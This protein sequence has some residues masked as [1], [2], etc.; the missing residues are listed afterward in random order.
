MCSNL[1]PLTKH[2]VNNIK[3]AKGVTIRAQNNLIITIK[4]ANG[5]TQTIVKKGDPWTANFAKLILNILLGGHHGGT[6]QAWTYT[7]GSTGTMIDTDAIG[8]NPTFAIAIGN[9]T[10]PFSVDDY[11]LSNQITLN[12]VPSDYIAFSDN[13]TCYNINA[14]SSFTVS[15]AVNITEVGLLIKVDSDISGSGTT[16][17]YILLSRDLLDTPVHLEANDTI[18]VQYVIYFSYGSPPLTKQFYALMLNY[19]FG[20][21]AYGKAISFK[22]TDGT[23]ASGSDFSIDYYNPDNVLYL[24]NV[25]ENLYAWLGNGSNIWGYDNYTLSNKIA[26]STS[27][28]PF[29]LT[30]NSTH[31]KFTVTITYSFSTSNT[32][33]EVGFVIQSIDIDTGTGSVYTPNRAKNVL[34]VYF[35]LDNPVYVES[36]GTFKFKCEIVLPLA[37]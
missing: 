26:T 9:G 4:R 22:C 5:E 19:I 33:T 7:D 1:I 13:G 27:T 11:T 24:D 8:F 2:F 12:D 16:A 31:A 18:S 34:V 15:Y 23:S 29:S 3:P 32:I 36:G 20:L 28:T 6:A 21:R 35:V 30:Y 10:T 14:T 17:N 25:H 37:G